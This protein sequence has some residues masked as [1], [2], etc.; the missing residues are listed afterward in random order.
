MIH[1]LAVIIIAAG[2]W[3]CLSHFG[4][5]K[6]ILIGKP[7]ATKALGSNKNLLFWLIALPVLS[8]DLYSS[9][10]YG[11]EA[12]MA[13]LAPLGASARWLLLPITV[14]SVAL[15]AT[16]II[17]YIMGVLAYPD[18][19]GAYAIAKDNFKN[20]ILSVTASSALLIDY[21]LTVAVSVSAAVAAIASAFPT[22]N[23]YRTTIALV[24]VL[25][26]LLLNLRGASEAAKIL[27]WP[28]FL[29]MACML[30]VI[31]SGFFNELKFGFIQAATPS[32]AT[33]PKDLST[34]LVLK[35]FSSSCSALTGIETISNSVPLFRKPKQK[36]AIKTYLALGLLESVTLLGIAWLFY[37]HGITVRSGSTMLSQL[38]QILFG[39]GPV[40]Q[41]ITWAT[42]VVL[43]LAA[44]ST[45]NGFSQLAA[46]VASDGFLPRKLAQRGDRLSYSNGLISL[47]TLASLLIVFFHAETNALIPLYAI[48]V[49]VS[50][51]IAQTGLVRRWHRIRGGHW[52]TYLVINS[53]G[54]VVSATVAII[55]AFTKFTSGAWLVLIILP[56]FALFSLKV[57]RHYQMV[58]AQLRIDLHKERPVAHKVVSIVLLSGIHR[59]VN[60]TLSFAKS[61]DTNV[62]AVY[63]GFD[64]TSIEKMQKQWEE[65]GNPC[66]LIVLKS[67]YRSLTNPIAAFIQQIEQ[68]EGPDCYI[69]ILMPQ[70][71]TKERWQNFLHNQSAL[72]LRTWLFF[73]KN[74]VITTVPFHLSE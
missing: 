32:F 10:A 51:T 57:H 14:A 3:L 20:P 62:M 60:N 46:I 27:A 41:V 59:V 43:I 2:A 16:L 9:V 54:G 74:V 66:K 56:L 71:I 1:V 58:A 63:V 49:F 17:S 21:I 38:T 53:I 34:L 25:V 69:H 35:A 50:F 64:D 22:I 28:T 7:M 6:R 70:F 8:A 30:A 67:Q 68:Q 55:F 52:K 39:N 18:G 13:E 72:I 31:V 61:I 24:C 23:P 48:G 36:N 40:Y 65:W 73:H 47:A 19:G 15:L 29:F 33:V 4:L 5:I 11:P 44:N 26:L 45:F 42:F 37:V 12:G